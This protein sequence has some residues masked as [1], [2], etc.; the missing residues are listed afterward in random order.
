LCL[1]VFH[2]IDFSWASGS[3]EFMVEE[4]ELLVVECEFGLNDGLDVVVGV[5]GGY[6]LY[7]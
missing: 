2:H 6:F 7:L 4:A 5:E 1:L 3:D